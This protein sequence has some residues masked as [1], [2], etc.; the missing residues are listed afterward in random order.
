MLGTLAGSS[1][2]PVRGSPG[3]VSARQCDRRRQQI[4]KPCQLSDVWRRRAKM[5]RRS[6]SF[7]V[8]ARTIYLDSGSIGGGAAQNEFQ[9]DGKQ[10]SCHVSQLLRILRFMPY[11]S[12]RAWTD[13][14]ALACVSPLRRS[15]CPS[16]KSRSTMRH[17]GVAPGA[18]L[19]TWFQSTYEKRNS[20]LDGEL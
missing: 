2:D 14:S 7:T 4:R 19:A 3:L 20:Y 1:N 11:W 12:V 5:C 9:T 8:L 18:P 13:H 6:R 10:V 17:C 15:I 16:A